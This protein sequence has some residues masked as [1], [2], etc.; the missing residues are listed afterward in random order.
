MQPLAS[1]VRFREK[2]L[3]VVQ[4]SCAL[5]AVHGRGNARWQRAAQGVSSARKLCKILRWIS[6]VRE[7]QVLMKEEDS[8]ARRRRMR[9]LS[10]A[11]AADVMLDLCFLERLGTLRAG[12]VPPWLSRLADWCDMAACVDALWIGVHAPAPH[13]PRAAGLQLLGL[14]ETAC[15]VMDLAHALQLPGTASSSV[16]TPLLYG[17]SSGVLSTTRI[18]V[19]AAPNGEPVAVELGAAIDFLGRLV[20]AR[21]RQRRPPDSEQS[22]FA[23]SVTPVAC[24]PAVDHNRTRQ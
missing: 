18:L 5:A 23:L 9:G 6:H 7:L 4:C 2:A 20:C 19:N 14:L 12:T 10:L 8:V 24:S 1:N 11:I 16:T 15:D 17:L 22:V 21:Q 3:K 13:E